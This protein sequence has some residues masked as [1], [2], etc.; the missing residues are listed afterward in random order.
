[1]SFADLEAGLGSAGRNNSAPAP[2]TPQDA[3]FVQ[4]QQSLSLQVFKINA[5]VQGMLK[6][7]DQLGT[8]RD[9]GSVRKSLHNLT[10][11][12]RDMAKRGTEDLKKLTTM[13]KDLPHHHAALTKTSHDFQVS[14]TALQRAQQ[15]SAERQRTVVESTKIAVEEDEARRE[16]SGSTPTSPGQQQTQLLQQRLSP[17]ELSHQESLITEREAEI[18]DIESGIH[19][20][21]EIFRDLGTLVSEQ[22]NMVDNIES[23]I[24]SVA[25]NTHAASD[26]L[27]TAHEYQRR[28]GRRAACLMMILVIVLCVVLL[29]VRLLMF[30]LIFTFGH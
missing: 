2:R 7:V 11:T 10:E 17:A 9:T 1:M 19:E 12:T 26:E 6:L 24:S 3:A 22:G 28:A 25:I 21:S 23:N 30:L 5:N 15:V 20:L 18:R 14:L 8:A 29:A 16:E 13:Q 27:T 4:L